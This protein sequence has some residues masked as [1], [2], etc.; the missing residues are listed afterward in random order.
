ML[1][2]PDI[3]AYIRGRVKRHII[4]LTADLAIFET[5]YNNGQY[6]KAGVE[7][8]IMASISTNQ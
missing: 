5:E 2:Q 6:W 1:A 4:A 7:L 3:E 8:G